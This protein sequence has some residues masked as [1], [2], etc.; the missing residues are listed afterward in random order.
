M[1]TSPDMPADIR[2][3]YAAGLDTHPGLV[4]SA[5]HHGVTLLA[6]TDQPVGA[7]VDKIVFLH[8]AG[9]SAHDAIGATSWTAREALGL[10]CLAENDRADLIWF[11]NDPRQDL[12]TL[13][14]GPHRD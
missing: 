12:E 13:R 3:W 14:A 8:G 9:L 7:L 5:K 6:G 1:M 2:Q 11:E 10:P 4:R